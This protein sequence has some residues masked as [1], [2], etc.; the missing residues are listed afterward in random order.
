MEKGLGETD[1]RDN[2]FH[3]VPSPILLAHKLS[4]A[5]IQTSQAPNQPPSLFPTRIQSCLSMD[6]LYELEWDSR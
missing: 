5:K 6:W 2:A 3:I 4:Q 1:R